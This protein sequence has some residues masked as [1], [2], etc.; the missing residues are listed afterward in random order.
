MSKQLSSY[1]DFMI[2]DI[3]ENNFLLCS[4]ENTYLLSDNE[5]AQRKELILKHK[6]GR[7]NNGKESVYIMASLMPLYNIPQASD[8]QIHVF[9][10]DNESFYFVGNDLSKKSEHM[11]TQLVKMYFS[12]NSNTLSDI[13]F[14]L[15]TC[16]VVRNGLN[17]KTTLLEKFSKIPMIN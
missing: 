14:K 9:D 2:Y 8:R 7:I 15:M 5:F 12:E 3:R 1:K 16:N 13:F 6:A 4:S 17:A 10:M 11:Q